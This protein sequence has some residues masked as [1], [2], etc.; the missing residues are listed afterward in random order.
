MDG[1]VHPLAM[2]T[3]GL[4]AHT[5]YCR[6]CATDKLYINQWVVLILCCARCWVIRTHAFGL[7]CKQQSGVLRAAAH[8]YSSLC[9]YVK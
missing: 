3:R 2:T 5:L 6:M 1:C 9:A 7:P 8:I 4:L